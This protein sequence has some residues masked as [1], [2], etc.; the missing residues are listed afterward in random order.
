M[1]SNLLETWRDPD[2]DQWFILS[3]YNYVYMY[4]AGTFWYNVASPLPLPNTEQLTLFFPF[5][6]QASGTPASFT[7]KVHVVRVESVRMIYT[8]VAPGMLPTHPLACTGLA[9]RS[10]R[11]LFSASCMLPSTLP[12]HEKAQC[13]NFAS[14]V[15]ASEIID[16]MARR[17]HQMR[18]SLN[19]FS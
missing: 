14:D 3:L 4:V 12:Q 19:T 6:T 8:K 15:K 18:T 2:K 7:A 16:H 11:T 5:A 17:P 1:D 13:S 10:L 9:N